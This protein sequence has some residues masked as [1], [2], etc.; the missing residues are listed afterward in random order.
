[1]LKDIWDLTYSQ[2]RRL[3]VLIIGS[4]VLLIGIALIV[5]PGPAV[6][7]IPAGLAILSLEFA[8]ARSFLARV[9]R[10]ISERH[11]RTRMDRL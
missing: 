4:S 6:I 3:A 10:E 8:W 11:R 5:L 1:M 2:A 9:R 7:V